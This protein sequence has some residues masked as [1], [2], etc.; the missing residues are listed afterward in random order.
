MNICQHTTGY[1]RIDVNGH[2]DTCY[3]T[4][5]NTPESMFLHL[6]NAVTLT[7]TPRHADTPRKA[8]WCGARILK[9]AIPDYLVRS[10]DLFPPEVS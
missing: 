7:N 1:E 5:R 8:H 6:H 9:H 3:S 2:N 4:Q 10:T